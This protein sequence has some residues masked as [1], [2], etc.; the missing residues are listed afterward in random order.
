MHPTI[1]EASIYRYKKFVHLMSCKKSGDL[2]I[3]TWSGTHLVH[4]DDYKRF[5]LNNTESGYTVNHNDSIPGGDLA[6]GYACTFVNWS[7]TFNEAYSS[8]P[9]SYKAWKLKP[10]AA[11]CEEWAKYGSVPLGND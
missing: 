7:K 11:A 1:I 5:C 6:N 2:F 3:F 9:P 10:I 4:H 8:L